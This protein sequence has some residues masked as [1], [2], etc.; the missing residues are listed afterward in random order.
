MFIYF[1]TRCPLPLLASLAA[2]R[3]FSAKVFVIF[4]KDSSIDAKLKLRRIELI[5][6]YM[7]S[8]R[9]VELFYS[10]YFPYLINLKNVLISEVK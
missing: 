9:I 8:F 10:P 4:V 6:F 2:H 7:P 3:N 5:G 1:P